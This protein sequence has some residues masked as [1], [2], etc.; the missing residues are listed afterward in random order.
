MSDRRI[1]ELNGTI[2]ENRV[3][4]Y[5]HH[6]Y[7]AC[8]VLQ[9][10]TLF[11]DFLG[12]DTQIDLIMVSTKGVF[13]IEAKGWRKWVKG[14]YD[15]HLWS[16]QSSQ[17]NVITTFSPVNQ[18]I[19][20]IRALRNAIRMTFGVE[21]VSFCNCVCFPDGTDIYSD[22]S[23]IVNLSRLGLLMDKLMISNGFHVDVNQYVNWIDT[24]C[25]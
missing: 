1:L 24:V 20:H 12:K 6:R 5:L 8:E 3:A 10:R 14:D 9:N 4:S 16:G 17:A 7:P 18:N 23:E 11:S 13:V 19:I 25:S 15:D 2:F 21:P 22:C